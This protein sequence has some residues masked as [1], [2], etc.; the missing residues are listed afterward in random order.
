MLI[1]GAKKRVTGPLSVVSLIIVSIVLVHAKSLSQ[2]TIDNQ[3]HPATRDVSTTDE[4]FGAELF[5]IEKRSFDQLGDSDVQ[6]PKRTLS[7]DFKN[8]HFMK[9][10]DF[11]RLGNSQ[12]NW[13]TEFTYRLG[14]Y[15]RDPRIISV[16]V[17]ADD[18]TLQRDEAN[19]GNIVSGNLYRTA[20][21]Y[22]VYEAYITTSIVGGVKKA[23]VTRAIDQG[24]VRLILGHHSANMRMTVHYDHIDG[25]GAG[26]P[27][28]LY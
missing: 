26:I 10:A 16:I 22:Q 12:A 24:I 23:R 7:R 5:A 1:S 11:S 9:Y 21:N 15:S 18:R 6:R 28:P 25:Y 19:A 8:K 3:N 14:F 4:F 2:L 20:Y 13:D 17:A 27:I